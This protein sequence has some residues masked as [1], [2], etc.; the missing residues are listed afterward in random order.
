MLKFKSFRAENNLITSLEIIAKEKGLNLSAL[1]RMILLEW[2]QYH[3][4]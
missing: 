1:I 2:L 3:K 4:K